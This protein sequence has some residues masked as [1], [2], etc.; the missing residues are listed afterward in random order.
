MRTD[1]NFYVAMNPLP[2][3][4]N[5]FRVDVNKR[6]VVSKAQEALACGEPHD[7]DPTITM[8][9]IFMLTPF[10]CYG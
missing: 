1:V 2:K 4:L 6:H 9:V 3:R 7:S 10:S 5:P 8:L